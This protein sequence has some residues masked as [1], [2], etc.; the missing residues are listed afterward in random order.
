MKFK[1][2]WWTKVNFLASFRFEL[3]SVWLFDCQF[4]PIAW[5]SPF[6]LNLNLNYR[7]LALWSKYS[8]S[9]MSKTFSPSLL[10]LWGTGQ[11]N[12]SSA[13]CCA[14]TTV[15]LMEGLR[16]TFFQCFRDR[17]ALSLSSPLGKARLNSGL[18]L[19]PFL[20]AEQKNSKDERDNLIEVV[21]D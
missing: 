19:I 4:D 2:W 17:S 12:S 13:S 21:G 1:R 7:T 20:R 6:N 14:R 16:W 5:W 10:F 3:A 15:H 18:S 11:Q 8:S 9:L